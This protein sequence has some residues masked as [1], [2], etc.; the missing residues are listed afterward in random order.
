MQAFPCANKPS[1][2]KRKGTTPKPVMSREGCHRKHFATCQD[3]TVKGALSELKNLEAVPRKS[4]KEYLG[5]V[6]KVQ[7]KSVQE[8]IWKAERY[9]PPTPRYLEVYQTTW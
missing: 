5:R 1:E 9:V 4:F 2:C 7:D 3:E 6:A 8:T